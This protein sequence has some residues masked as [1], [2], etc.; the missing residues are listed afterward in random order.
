MLACWQMGSGVGR[1]DPRLAQHSAR[2]LGDLGTGHCGLLRK[3][4][5]EMCGRETAKGGHDR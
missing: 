5:L 3:A 2:G 1:Q 4:G